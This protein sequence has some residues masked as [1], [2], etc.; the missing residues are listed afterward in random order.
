MA[1]TTAT[2]ASHPPWLCRGAAVHPQPP[3][4]PPP[5]PPPP[6]APAVP[7]AP[8]ALP[9]PPDPP[10][11]PPA[12]PPPPPSVPPSGVPEQES[13]L[14]EISASQFAASNWH[15]GATVSMPVFQLSVQTEAVQAS[16]PRTCLTA[17]SEV[18]GFVVASVKFAFAANP[19]DI[20][21]VG[22]SG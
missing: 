22:T 20:P 2:R 18:S 16:G 7:P 10:L 6:P 17:R 19:S 4:L 13:M 14:A 12:P 5:P 8:A 15:T 9:R 21:G 11:V 3:A 1:K